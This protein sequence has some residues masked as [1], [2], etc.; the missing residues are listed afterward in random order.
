MGRN[1]P[2]ITGDRLLF[3]HDFEPLLLQAFAR[4]QPADPLGQQLA[5]LLDELHDLT[6]WRQ[7][8][9]QRGG[10]LL[11]D[12]AILRK[13]AEGQVVIEGFHEMNLGT[14]SYDVT[15]GPHY[16]RE[17]RTD[18]RKAPVIHGRDQVYPIFNP[19]HP[20]GVADVWGEPQRAKSLQESDLKV[21]GVLEGIPPDHPLIWI[22]PGETLLCH[23]QEFIGGRAP[24][25]TTMM[26]A[27][28]TIGRIFIEVCKCAGWGD[29]GYVNRWT[30]EVT[31]NAERYAI[32][33]PVGLRIGQ[34]AFFEVEPIRD[35]SYAQS[36][37]YQSTDNIAELKSAWQPA[38]M[39]PKLYRDRELGKWRILD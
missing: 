6:E 8:A 33:L 9:A 4:S 1:Q 36:G 30:M 13:M 19:F 31:N 21:D 24:D 14:V 37:K 17:W 5:R 10:G 12:T 35:R 18:M 2:V 27:R 20:E 23:T 28:S 3:A 25:V 16:Y 7:I 29:V 32:P 26:K 39:L 22:F 38:N 34:M 15:L 11:S